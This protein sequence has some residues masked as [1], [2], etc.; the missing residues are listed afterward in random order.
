MLELRNNFE[1][2]TWTLHAQREFYIRKRIWYFAK[3]LLFTEQ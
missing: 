2:R 3:C 1:T